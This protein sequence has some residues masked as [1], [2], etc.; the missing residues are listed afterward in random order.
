M[1]SAGAFFFLKYKS[2]EKKSSGDTP[3]GLKTLF[4]GGRQA[5]ARAKN[6]YFLSA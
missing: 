2:T 1:T 4:C 3:Q 6:R 5:T